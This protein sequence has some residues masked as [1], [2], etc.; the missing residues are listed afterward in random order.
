[1]KVLA[2]VQVFSNVPLLAKLDS[3]IK[4]SLASKLRV[5]VW[6]PFQRI[7]RE[8]EQVS[9]STRRLYI[10]ESGK[11]V[12]SQIHS[13]PEEKGTSDSAKKVVTRQRSVFMSKEKTVQAG[14]YFGMF[15]F[16]YGCSQLNSLTA[17]TEAMTLSISYDEMREFLEEEVPDRANEIFDGMLTN[18]RKFMIKEAHPLLKTCND[19]E[20]T[21][22]LACAKTKR[23]EKWEPILR[24]GERLEKMSLLEA[25]C[26]IDYDGNAEDLMEK[27]MEE[28]DV[29]EHSRPGETFG[30]KSVVGKKD[31]VAAYT[32][33]AVSPVRILNISKEKIDALPRFASS[34]C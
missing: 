15:E 13:A 17:I 30:T 24:K 20:L 19:A 25:G 33:V 8:N 11:L 21:S 9:S 2:R 12:S 27:T 7:L 5:D 29:T 4:V 26:C 22:L 14:A 34:R 31:P 23:F 16:L 32:L 3:Q 1:M 6:Q 18:V 10:V 28:V